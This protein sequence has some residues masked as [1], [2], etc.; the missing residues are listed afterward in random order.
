MLGLS[1]D[2]LGAVA[3]T[4]LKRGSCGNIRN[5][6]LSYLL[7]CVLTTCHCNY[8]SLNAV[9]PKPIAEMSL[10]KPMSSQC[11]FS[12]SQFDPE[13][14]SRRPFGHGF[15]IYEDEDTQLTELNSDQV[16]VP[17]EYQRTN[18]DS[19]VAIAESGPS[20]DTPFDYTWVQWDAHEL[21][22]YARM[23]KHVRR[24][25]WWWRFGVPLTGKYTHM[26]SQKEFNGTHFLCRTCHMVAP[27][28]TKPLNISNGSQHVLDHFK[29]VHYNTYTENVD[30]PLAAL[31][32]P[33]AIEALDL[34]DPI[35][36]KQYNDIAELFD[37]SLIQKDILRW[38]TLENIPFKKLQSPYF[39]RIFKHTHPLMQNSVI[40]SEKVARQWIN[41]EFQLHKAE[42]Q[43]KL[44]SAASR[45]HLSF[46]L[47]TSQRCKAINGVVANFLDCQG[48]CQTALL[49][50]KE[51]ADRHNG[52]A[53]AANVLAVINDY[54]LREKVGFF[55]LDNASSNDT[56]V[57]VL[58]QELG[59]N[60]T[61]RRLRCAGHI[62]NLIAQQ[63][64]FGS[65]FE[66][67]E[68]EVARVDTLKEEV[69][70]W[71][72]QGPIGMIATIVRWINK[73]PGR[74]KRFENAQL[75][76][77]RRENPAS[78][79]KCNILRL[80]MDNSTRYVSLS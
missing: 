47:W 55:V 73:S 41:N 25:A 18:D 5:P 42:V 70:I 39:Q 60:P 11:G 24:T 6:T 37:P 45:I 49:A 16:P 50:F 56:A 51:M 3:H 30:G 32:K 17:T 23:A 75:D 79:G 36:Q 76:V 64:L 68:R 72:A 19:H 80:K 77:W 58:G 20:C 13:P 61:W 1:G 15:T 63:L 66:M 22:G 52:E 69:K 2:A 10:K 43:E 67:F 57:S 46:D 12:E 28:S 53:I 26:R 33:N 78:N 65:N 54:D 14:S 48:K 35:Q 59:F 40:P 44:K 62:L 29:I 74:I 38:V 9:Y 34:T 71:R 8:C 21:K 4:R 31:D 7:L 27:S